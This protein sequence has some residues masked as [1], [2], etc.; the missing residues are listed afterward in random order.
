MTNVDNQMKELV[1]I[2]LALLGPRRQALL[3]LVILHD[4]YCLIGLDVMEVGKVYQKLLHGVLEV[5]E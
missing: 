2:L 1:V 3:N 4:C 5:I